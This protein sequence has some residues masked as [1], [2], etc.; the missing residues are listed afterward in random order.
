MLLDRQRS[1]E[2]VKLGDVSRDRGHPA[3]V[4]LDP[5]GV[6]FAGRNLKLRPYPVSHFRKSFPNLNCTFSPPRFWYVKALS[7]VDFPAEEGPMTATNSPFL[8]YPDTFL[9]EQ[10]R[11]K[12]Y[13]NSAN[14]QD[15]QKY[16]SKHSSIHNITF[17]ISITY[18]FFANI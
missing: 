16:Y 11:E 4:H 17:F 2:E 3:R 1:D 15:L 13:V 7:K 12:N 8:T 5:V 18:L 9:M 14:L 10:E 6:P